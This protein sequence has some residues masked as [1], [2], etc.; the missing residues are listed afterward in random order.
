[1]SGSASKNKPAHPFGVY[2]SAGGCPTL[3][4]MSGAGGTAKRRADWAFVSGVS[5]V[6]PNL[7][8]IERIQR[9]KVGYGRK[10]IN[11]PQGPCAETGGTGATVTRA[12]GE[13]TG[14]RRVWDRWDHPTLDQGVTVRGCDGAR[15]RRLNLVTRLRGSPRLALILGES[16]NALPNGSPRRR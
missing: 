14:A 16:S 12:S 7:K 2:V 13:T 6:S 3:A 11:W 9:E 8:L 15:T 1:M 4:H 5:P 10:G